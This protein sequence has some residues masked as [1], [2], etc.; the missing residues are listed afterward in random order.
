MKLIA[1]V[2]SGALAAAEF[3]GIV[4]DSMCGLNHKMMNITPDAK[5]AAECVRGSQA[6]KWALVDGKSTYKLSD[7]T[8]PA[9]FA[10]QRVKVTG[11]LFPKTG[12]IQVEK[13]ELSA[14]RAKPE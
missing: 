14:P 1:L 9:K 5:C 7:Q 11:K 3:Q 10:A 12:V 8:L 2:F 6:V 4:T 13:I